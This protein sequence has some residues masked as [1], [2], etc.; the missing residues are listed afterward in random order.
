MEVTDSSCYFGHVALYAWNI[1]TDKKVPGGFHLSLS[2][3]LISGMSI[4]TIKLVAT[5]CLFNSMFNFVF[6]GL[7]FFFHS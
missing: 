4:G 1:F 2:L 3:S 7:H 6:L 5:A